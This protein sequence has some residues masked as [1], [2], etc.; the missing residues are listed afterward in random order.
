ML[1]WTMVEE[2]AA[3]H[4]LDNLLDPRDNQHLRVSSIGSC[5]REIGYRITDYR[6]GV[7]EPPIWGHGR[8]IFELGHGV[9]IQLQQ[10]LSNVGS[11]KWVDADPALDEHGRFA[12]KGNIEIPVRDPELRLRGTMD[13]LTR[14]LRRKRLRTGA[15]AFFDVLEPV[16]EEERGTRYV[17]D[18]KTISA[19]E[20]LVVDYNGRGEVKDA[21]VK[22]SAFEKLEKPK[23]EHIAQASLYSWLSTRPGFETDR[24]AGPLTTLPHVMILYV[25]KD[26]DGEYYR[27]HPEEYAD[28]QGLLNAPYKVFTQAVDPALVEKMLEKVRSVWEHLD[29]DELPPRDYNCTERWKDFACQYCSW[30]SRCWEDEGY[31]QDQPTELP[32][33]VL[34]HRQKLKSRPNGKNGTTG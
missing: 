14:P 1:D 4:H 28:P 26:L 17:I 27:R 8:S 21:Q 29:K 7:E 33:R 22:P 25:A 30:R 15:E 6:Q 19:R 3:S 31:F 24:I 9:H 10:R 16:E 5:R 34:Y 23:P 11:L 12:W 32:L 13:A 18:V 2:L 20:K